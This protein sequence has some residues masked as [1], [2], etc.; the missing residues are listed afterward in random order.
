MIALT[1]ATGFLGGFVAAALA[2]AG[3]P[4][5]AI[6][7][8]RE[9]AADLAALPGASLAA[10]S[11]EDYPS[12]AAALRGCSGLIN[13]AS[14]GFGHAPAVV[15]A[16][17]DAGIERALFI[18]STAIFTR[19]PAASVGPRREGEKVVTQSGLAWTVL[20]PTMIYGTERDRNIFRLLRF[21]R[22]SPVFPMIGSGEYLQQPIHVADVAAAVLKAYASHRT[23]GKAYN[24]AGEAPLTF[25]AVVRTAAAVLGRRVALLH[26]PA[27]LVIPPLALYERLVPRPRLKVEQIRRLAEDK[28]FD[29]RE[30][31]QDFG[32]HSRSFA[33]GVTAEVA[34]CQRAGLL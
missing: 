26:V 27:A 24:L 12:L 7:R 18:S 19:L 5:R 6:V 21:L 25:N 8:S 33:A 9:R 15:A 2:A 28:A 16:A 23:I 10:G 1:G 20:R 3:I 29:C 14:L 31:A 11:F 22:R 13:L 4:F 17:V 34:H 32:F 30:A